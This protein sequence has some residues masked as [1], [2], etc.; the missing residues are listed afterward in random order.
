MASSA[1]SKPTAS[2]LNFA[3]GQTVANLAELGLGTG[4]KVSVF[5]PAG[6]VNVVVDVEG[7]VGPSATPGTGLYNPLAPARSMLDRGPKQPPTDFDQWADQVPPPN[8][9]ARPGTEWR[10][11]TAATPRIP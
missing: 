1:T 5:N 9:P 4:G 10:R 7:Y 2:N 6:T 11:P 8:R 3:P